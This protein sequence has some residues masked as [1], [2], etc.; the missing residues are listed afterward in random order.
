V[1][2]YIFNWIRLLRAPSGLAWN[3][4][5]DGA[6]PISLGNLGQC[7]WNLPHLPVLTELWTKASQHDPKGHVSDSS[8]LPITSA[9]IRQM[10]I[11]KL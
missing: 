8:A 1:S 2:R 10:V 7:F 11:D 4:S 5:R 3:V 6:S 9:G